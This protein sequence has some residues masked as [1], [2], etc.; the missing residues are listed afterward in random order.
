MF[1]QNLRDME[2]H[3][4][5]GFSVG[6]RLQI[7]RAMAF[8]LDAATCLLL[9]VLHIR[10]AVADDLSTQVEP[11]NRVESDGDFLRG[12]FSLHEISQRVTIWAKQK[13][14]LDRIRP[15]RPALGLG[16]GNDVRPRAGVTLAASTR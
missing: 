14:V 16:G 11:R 2:E 8:D 7:A 3:I 6:G 10:A 1:G 12:P 4:F 9:Y 15:A 5:L 13:H